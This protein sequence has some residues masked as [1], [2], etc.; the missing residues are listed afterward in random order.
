M[1]DI[2]KIELVVNEVFDNCEVR[3]NYEV[4]NMDMDGNVNKN[5][6]CNVIGYCL[7]GVEYKFVCINGMCICECKNDLYDWSIDC[8][9]LNKDELKD[10]LESL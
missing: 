2:E 7:D 6:N 8:V 4:E 5:V 1:L 3:E 9:V 10:Y